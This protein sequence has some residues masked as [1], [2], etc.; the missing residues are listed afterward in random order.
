MSYLL[1]MDESGHDHKA[2]PY[3]VRGGIALHASK[4]WPFVRAIRTL[5]ESMFGD[6]LHRYRTELKGYKLLDK[7]RFAFAAQD[8]ILD[9]TARRKHC[10]AFLNKGVERKK[11]SRIEFTS[12]G[13]ACLGMARGIFQLLRDNDAV[14]FASVIPRAVRRPPTGEYEE[15]LRKDHVFLLE[16]YYYFLE[17]KQEQGLLVMDET[18]KRLDRKFVRQ[19]YRYFT[20]TEMGRIRTQ[21]V[22]PAPFFV[23]SDMAYPIQAADVCIYCLNWG[24]RL[25]LQRMNASTRPE[26][27][28]EFAS[29]LGQMQ[30]KGEGEKGGKVYRMFGIK[31]VPDPYTSRTK[32][33]GNAFGATEIDSP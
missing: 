1:F 14:L 30:F 21:W 7:D 28:D 33:G 32:K 10:L 11:P 31:Y 20:D 19:M 12:F 25:P 8:D 5:E 6:L 17:E 3:E 2:L 18:E 24:F 27:H 22:V 26:I 29:W 9:D 15:L 4:V 16:R 13:Q 23:S